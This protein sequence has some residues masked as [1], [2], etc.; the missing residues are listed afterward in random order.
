MKRSIKYGLV[1]FV[2]LL[3]WIILM[4]NKEHFSSD[5]Y[6]IV[7]VIPWYMLICLGCYC[8]FKLG[9]EVLFFNDCQSDIK[10]LERVRQYLNI[11]QH[12]IHNFVFVSI[13]DVAEAKADLRK[14]GFVQQHYQF[15]KLQDDIM[16]LAVEQLLR[17]SSCV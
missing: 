6:F 16:Y 7:K 5:T 8:L 12:F 14:R 3:S 9:T 17:N 11:I 4:A 1:L 10:L 15:Q 13:Q 2:L